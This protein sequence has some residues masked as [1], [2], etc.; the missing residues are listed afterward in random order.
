MV[1]V[2]RM[3][4]ELLRLGADAGDRRAD[5]VHD[6]PRRLRARS[7]A[8]WTACARS[9]TSSRAS[10]SAWSAGTRQ[11]RGRSSRASDA[12]RRPDPRAPRRTA[13]GISSTGRS[14]SCVEA[15]GDGAG[16]AVERGWRRFETVLDELVAELPTLR[17]DGRRDRRLARTGRAANASRPAGRIR[18]RFITPMA[19]VA[20]AVADEMIAAMAQPESPRPTSTTAATSRC[21]S[22][23]G[24]RLRVGVVADPDRATRHGHRL[25]ARRRLRS[26]RRRCRCAAWRRAAG[27][28]AAGASGIADSVTVLAASG[29]AADA[30]ATMI[31]NAVDVDQ[32]GDP[33]PAAR[34]TSTTTPTSAIGW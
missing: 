10:A 4:D 26:R 7:A 20:G 11:S 16:A 15:F 22:A 21:I 24:E 33:T 34:A 17:R 27:A 8:T 19:A 12:R 9:R 18:E 31:A 6:A 13:A 2:M 5:R 23:P 29:A 30:A 14:T 28:D 25:A 1:D 32:P 3:P